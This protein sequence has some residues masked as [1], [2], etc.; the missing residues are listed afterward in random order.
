MANYVHVVPPHLLLATRTVSNDVTGPAANGVIADLGALAAGQWLIRV[1]T[2]YSGNLTAAETSK[3][4]TLI[5]RTIVV[6]N[7]FTAPVAGAPGVWQEFVITADGTNH[8][9]I[10]A[11][12]AGGAS[13][14]YSAHLEAYQIQTA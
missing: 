4:M 9:E 11:T 14:V 3:N 7:L 10:Q 6:A 5:S 8:V 2:S 1:L 13:A 12:N